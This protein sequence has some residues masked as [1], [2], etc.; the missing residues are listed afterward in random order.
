MLL[1]K[2]IEV[3]TSGKNIKYLEEKGYIVPKHYNSR[4]E[5]V[6]NQNNKIT[7]KVNDLQKSSTVKVDVECDCCKNI[8]NISYDCYASG[9]KEDGKYYCKKCYKIYYSMSFEEWCINNNHKDYL[10]LW[11]Y[12]LND[13]KPSQVAFGSNEKYWFKCNKNIHDSYKRQIGLITKCKY[14]NGLCDKCNSFG[15]YLIDTY[16]DNAIIER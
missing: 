9:V 2:E 1:T 13:K 14:E 11:D 16:G 8:I 7:I 15:Q 6:V 12:D 4:G 3:R 5:L 10:D